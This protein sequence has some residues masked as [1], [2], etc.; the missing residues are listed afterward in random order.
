MSEQPNLFD[1]APPAEASDLL[2]GL[3]VKLPDKCRYE[4]AVALIGPGSGPHKAALRCGCG[5][6][7]GWVSNASFAFLQKIVETFGRPTTPI[8]IQRGSAC[9][10]ITKQDE[11]LKRKF[12]PEGV[13]WFDIISEASGFAPESSS[14]EE[15][16][17]IAPAPIDA[18]QGNQSTRVEKENQTK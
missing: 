14:P 12:T 11:Y 13:S 3:E 6:H 7:R 4:R 18:G 10:Q 16:N 8:A 2:I 5:K 1:T 15:T 9:A 17:E